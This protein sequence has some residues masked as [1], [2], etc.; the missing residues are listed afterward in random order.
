M[1]TLLPRSDILPVSERE[2]GLGDAARNPGEKVLGRLDDLAMVS[3]PEVA[4][5]EYV[6]R[7][8]REAQRRHF[9][10]ILLRS[11]VPVSAS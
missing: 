11:R 7:V 2:L 6:P 3:A 10:D 4:R 5:F 1:K 8:V 9:P